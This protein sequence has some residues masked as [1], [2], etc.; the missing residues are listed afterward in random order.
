MSVRAA[1]CLCASLVWFQL[2]HT[3]LSTNLYPVPITSCHMWR[4]WYWKLVLQIASRLVNNSH[5]GLSASFHPV[6]LVLKRWSAWYKYNLKFSFQEKVLPCLWSLT[7]RK[8][9]TIN[10]C[11]VL[12]LLE[13][14]KLLAFYPWI[15][16]MWCVALIAPGSHPAPT[17]ETRLRVEMILQVAG[18]VGATQWQDEIQSLLT[19]SRSV[20]LVL[21][22]WT[23]PIVSSNKSVCG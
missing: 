12:P 8:K 13:S 9:F 4:G 22:F 11:K 10:L 19:V 14:L 17:K 16:T 7:C 2:S 18:G 3:E 5:A 6:A 1:L 23:P 20:S 15:R 21:Y